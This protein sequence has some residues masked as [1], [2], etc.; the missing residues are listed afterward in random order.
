MTVDHD[1]VVLGG[2]P[3]G[4]AAATALAMRGRAVAVLERGNFGGPRV[5]ETLGP[6]VGPLLRALGLWD[7]FIALEQFPFRGVRSAWGSEAAVERSAILNP[8]GDGW[9]VDRAQFDALLAR[10]AAAAGAILHEGVGVAAITPAEDGW[11]L[12][13]PGVELRCRF[14]VDAS[15]RGAPGGAAGIPGRRW[16]ACDRL[17]ALVARMNP[18][19]DRPLDPELLIETAEEGWWYAVPQPGNTL[20]ISLLT[21]VDLAVAAGP[22]PE[23]SARWEAALSRTNHVRELASGATLE[24]PPRIVRADTGRLLPDR[25][26]Q[27]R[28]VG[29]AAV[30]GDPL[31]GDGV[32]RGLRSALDAAADIDRALAGESLADAPDAASFVAYLDRRI[33]YYRMEQRWSDALFWKRRHGVDWESMPITLD[34]RRVLSWDG[35]EPAADVIA[36][37]EALLPPRAIRAVLERLARP[38]PAHEALAALRDAAPLGD[39]RLLVGVQLLVEAGFLGSQ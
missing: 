13:A 5:G 34:P 26:P 3:S 32:A 1:V 17:V 20:L 28:A 2:G 19:A 37:I 33:R 9:H 6:Q 27:W 8:L 39:R 10:R 31:S 18:P 23:L 14:L 36:P 21:D 22:R 35:R 4:L 7:D 30:G 25:G 11:R 24:G 29:D 12:Q 38:C 16:L 15:G